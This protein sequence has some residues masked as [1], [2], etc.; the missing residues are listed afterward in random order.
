MSRNGGGMKASSDKM[1][2]KYKYCD[3]SDAKPVAET[4]HLAKLQKEAGGKGRG[5][6]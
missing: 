6:L 3:F 2:E 4:P 5:W 1:Y